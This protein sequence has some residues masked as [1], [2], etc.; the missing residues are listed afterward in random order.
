MPIS[1]IAAL[2][3]AENVYDYAN[4]DADDHVNYMAHI[5]GA[6]IGALAGLIYRL[7]NREYLERLM[8]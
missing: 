3:V 7:T 6:A 5:S 2:Y 1:V 8:A 4:V